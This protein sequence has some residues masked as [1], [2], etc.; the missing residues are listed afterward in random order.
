MGAKVGIESAES[1]PAIRRMVGA[2]EERRD[3]VVDALEKIP[4]VQCQKPRGAFYVFPNVA[5]LC[6]SI[7][8]FEG[9]SALPSSIRDRTSPATLLQ[10]FLLF[11]YQVATMDRRSFGRIGAEGEHFLRI[12]IATSRE[13]LRE[14][15]ARIDAASRDRGGFRAFLRGSGRFA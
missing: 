4:G 10:M 5:G 9:Y 15:V 12:S 8:A 2:F 6:E 13:D 14:A 11:R 3:L 1:A 7:G